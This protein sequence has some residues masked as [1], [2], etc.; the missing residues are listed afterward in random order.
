M[1]NNEY[2][3][4]DVYNGRCF[5]RKETM[6]VETFVRRANLYDIIPA[7]NSILLSSIISTILMK[8][9]VATFYIVLPNKDNKLSFKKLI[10]GK[11]FLECLYSFVANLCS[12]PNDFPKIPCIAENHSGKGIIIM[13]DISGRYFKDLPEMLQEKI[14]WYNLDFVE[15]ENYTDEDITKLERIF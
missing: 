11:C 7:Y 12:I 10:N 13:Y 9:P 14:L 5:N 6:S 3:L 1:N 4:K 2:I 15:L 8:C